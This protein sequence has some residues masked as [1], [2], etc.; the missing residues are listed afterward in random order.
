MSPYSF[1]WVGT[2]STCETGP[3]RLERPAMTTEDEMK[4]P[5]KHRTLVGCDRRPAPAVDPRRDLSGRLAASAGRAGRGLRREPH[6]GARS[7]VSARGRRA[8]AYR[9]AKGR[10]RLGAVAGRNQRRVRSARDHGAA[11]VGAVGAA[12]YGNRTL[13]GWTTSR[14]ASRRRSR[15][16][17]SASGASSMPTSIWRCTFTRGSRGP[18]RSSSRCCRPAT[19]TRACSFPTPRRW[20]RPKKNTPT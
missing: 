16:A 4:V 6:S 15:R 7:A 20:G 3:S 19:A 12:L 17:T 14:S 2:A 11:A 18:R 8:G 13:P 1:C 5:L 10:D 9:P